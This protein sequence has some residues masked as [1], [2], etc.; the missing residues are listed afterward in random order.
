MNF[1]ILKGTKIHHSLLTVQHA[2]KQTCSHM[3]LHT[4]F[5]LSSATEKTRAAFK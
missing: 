3:P 5:T 4:Y 1:S 2:S